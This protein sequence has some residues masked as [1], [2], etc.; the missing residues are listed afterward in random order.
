LKPRAHQ[1][2][3]RSSPVDGG[4]GRV[5]VVVLL[6]ILS[7]PLPGVSNPSDSEINET[8]AR[9]LEHRA[10]QTEF[11]GEDATG[12]RGRNRSLSS[13][14]GWRG[15]PMTIDIRPIRTVAGIVRLL[16]WFVFAVILA[17]LVAWATNE[18]VLMAR[19]ERTLQSAP[20]EMSQASV[21]TTR[22]SLDQAQKLAERGDL[23]AAVRTLLAATLLHL[24][25][26]GIVSLRRS[27]TGREA[28]RQVRDHS[29][30]RRHLAVL[31]VAVEHSCFGGLSLNHDDFERCR[32]AVNAILEPA[33]DAP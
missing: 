29:D 19:R 5:A 26:G 18:A 25:S 13:S 24:A 17:V 16:F 1:P 6:S 2:R 14:G 15:E 22:F 32:A 10:F 23:V 8:A 4:W 7:A 9:V 3:D 31:V 12:G 33:V 11:P 21:A 20:D 30:L 28:L 27:T